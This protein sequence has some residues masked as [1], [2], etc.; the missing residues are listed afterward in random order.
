MSSYGH[1]SVCEKCLVAK[2]HILQQKCLNKWIRTVPPPETW[3]C[4]FQSPIPTLSPQ[5]PHLLNHNFGVIWRINSNL[6]ANNRK[7]IQIYTPGRAIISMRQGYSK[8]HHTIGSFSA[9]ADC[10]VWQSIEVRPKANSQS[11]HLW[12]VAASCLQVNFPSRH[13]ITRI[14]ALKE[15]RTNFKSEKGRPIPGWTLASLVILYQLWNFQGNRPLA[16]ENACFLHH[17][18]LSE[19][20]FT[21]YPVIGVK[22]FGFPF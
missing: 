10:L 2:W 14:K 17:F 8:H 19:P 12:D 4:N 20:A 21:D 18:F 1:L 7:T 16:C 15:Y 5:T 3:F 6:T 11:E 9:I 22:L 13:L